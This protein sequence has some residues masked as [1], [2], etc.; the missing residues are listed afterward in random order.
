M[1]RRS[2][3]GA[4][5]TAKRIVRKEKKMGLDIVNEG[6]VRAFQEHCVMLRPV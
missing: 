4:W 6:L 1:D 2:Q 3:D 5:A